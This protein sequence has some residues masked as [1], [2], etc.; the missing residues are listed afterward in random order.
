MESRVRI[1]FTCE[2]SRPA[3]RWTCASTSAIGTFKCKMKNAKCR[4]L[5]RQLGASGW[6]GF[7]VSP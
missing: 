5:L 1:A 2:V 7:P 3:A 6:I 4:M